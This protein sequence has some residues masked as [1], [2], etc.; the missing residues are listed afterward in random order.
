MLGP[1]NTT[2]N[3]SLMTVHY[4][5]RTLLLLLFSVFILLFYTRERVESV[6]PAAAA[7]QPR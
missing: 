2:R 6:D 3:Y 7:G 5:S 4:Y 1:V